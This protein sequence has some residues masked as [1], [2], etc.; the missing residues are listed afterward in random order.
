MIYFKKK[1][2]SIIFQMNNKKPLAIVIRV[3]S[4]IESVS[5]DLQ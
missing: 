5:L 2:W 1:L 4:L 3:I